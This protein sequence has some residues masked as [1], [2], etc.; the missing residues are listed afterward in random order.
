MKNQSFPFW[1]QPTLHFNFEP[2]NYT[3]AGG[4]S[5]WS[6][7]NPSNL[8][9]LYSSKATHFLVI[10]HAIWTRWLTSLHDLR[11]GNIDWF[12][13]AGI[14]RMPLAAQRIKSREFERDQA[15]NR[16]NCGPPSECSSNLL[17]HLRESLQEKKRLAS[18]K[19]LC[20]AAFP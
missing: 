14:M 18:H 20:Y 9:M 13:N 5:E 16:L 19:R 1:T 3:L 12:N 11:T 10:N 7:W 17:L 15:T 8:K 2:F 4:S 6:D